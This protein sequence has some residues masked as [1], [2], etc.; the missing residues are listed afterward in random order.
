M[1]DTSHVCSKCMKLALKYPAIWANEWNG[2]PPMVPVT[3]RGSLWG[4][5][6][7]MTGGHDQVM[8]CDQKSSQNWYQGTAVDET[9]STTS[10][11]RTKCTT[12]GSISYNYITNSKDCATYIVAT[13]WR[14]ET[15]K[16]LSWEI[17]L[18]NLF[19]IISLG[20]GEV[21]RSHHYNWFT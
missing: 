20:P 6:C 17:T 9:S 5:W 2:V 19:L 4:L 1:K 3:I 8:P 15:R 7:C 18:T 13:N 11:I 10:N 21:G 12:W 16:L 14:L